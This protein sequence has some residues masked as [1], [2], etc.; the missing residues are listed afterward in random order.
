MHLNFVADT[1]CSAF[2]AFQINAMINID[3]SIMFVV[4]FGKCRPSRFMLFVEMTIFKWIWPTL[5]HTAAHS[6]CRFR[7]LLLVFFSPRNLVNYSTGVTFVN[8]S[9]FSSLNRLFFGC[10]YGYSS[11]NLF[12][13]RFSSNLI[14]LLRMPLYCFKFCFLLAVVL[15]RHAQYY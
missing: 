7:W 5:S 15:C 9:A 10:R 14:I 12:F 8:V 2:Y 13:F 1:I 4:P 3:M 11:W 6:L